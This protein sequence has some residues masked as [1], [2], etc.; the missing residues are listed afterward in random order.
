[1]KLSHSGGQAENSNIRTPEK[2]KLDRLKH[3]F[4][5]CFINF[6]DEEVRAGERKILG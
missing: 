6:V 5:V 2:R 1:M 4:F 3:T